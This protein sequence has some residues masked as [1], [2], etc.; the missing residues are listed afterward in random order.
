MQP[1]LPCCDL[2]PCYTKSEERMI[3]F[4]G[5]KTDHDKLTRE[6]NTESINNNASN[7]IPHNLHKLSSC[8]FL[9]ITPKNLGLLTQF[10]KK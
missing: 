9:K 8:V 7:Y 10:V 5:T 2:Q 3:S 6:N 1:D 4:E